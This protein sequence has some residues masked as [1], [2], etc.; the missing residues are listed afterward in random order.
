MIKIDTKDDGV[1]KNDTIENDMIEIDLIVNDTTKI[2]EQDIIQ[3]DLIKMDMMLI[4][5]NPS[6]AN[7]F[8]FIIYKCL[9][10]DSL[11]LVFWP[12]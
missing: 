7:N 2:L 1:M 12:F 10:D 6:Y 11:L 9:L 8:L 5:T 3:V 4:D